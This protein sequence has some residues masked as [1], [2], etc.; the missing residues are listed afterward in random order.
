[1]IVEQFGLI[2]STVDI[3]LSDVWVWMLSHLSSKKVTSVD[4][5]VNLSTRIS[6]TAICRENSSRAGK[7]GVLWTQNYDLFTANICLF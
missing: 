5:T 3:Q 6:L 7:P 4:P 1:M 2:S